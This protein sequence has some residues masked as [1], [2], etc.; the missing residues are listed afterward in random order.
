[1]IY[2]IIYFLIKYVNTVNILPCKKIPYKDR[3][4][5]VILYK[6]RIF[7]PRITDLNNIHVIWKLQNDFK[8]FTFKSW[9]KKMDLSKEFVFFY[10]LKATKHL[11]TDFG[12]Y[13]VIWYS[14]SNTIINFQYHILWLIYWSMSHHINILAM[15]N[16]QGHH[17][18]RNYKIFVSLR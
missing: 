1:M 4:R 6:P 10:I 2:M 13:L 15:L 5:N 3:R 7:M 16:W 17:V 14:N 11:E 18:S 8:I 12:D 9:S